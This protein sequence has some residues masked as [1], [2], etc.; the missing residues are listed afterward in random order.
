M[1][2][3]ELSTKC[4]CPC[5]VSEEGDTQVGGC[6]GLNENNPH[7]PRGSDTIRRCGLVE[8]SVSLEVGFVVF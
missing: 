6:G 1:A 8:E 5:I 4:V 7:R 3:R 2:G